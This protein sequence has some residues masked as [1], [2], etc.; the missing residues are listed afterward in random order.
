M[1][2]FDLS[3]LGPDDPALMLAMRRSLDTYHNET[4]DTDVPGPLKSPGARSGLIDAIN[5]GSFRLTLPQR[6]K[7][8]RG[9]EVCQPAKLDGLLTRSGKLRAALT[10]AQEKRARDI[11]DCGCAV[12]LN[13]DL[14]GRLFRVV[15]CESLVH[16]DCLVRWV[17][18]GHDTCPVCRADPVR[19]KN[20]QA[21][22]SRHFA[23][24]TDGER[25]ALLTDG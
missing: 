5:A 10:V 1:E 21:S 8:L 7:Q 12:C 19:P 15:C 25:A 22:N 18:L 13:P 11:L 23:A 9:M 4:V 24:C 17:E 16:T 6:V 3:P 2:V 14:R 20:G